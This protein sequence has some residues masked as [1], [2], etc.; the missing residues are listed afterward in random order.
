[1]PEAFES[2]ADAPHPCVSSQSRPGRTWQRI[3]QGVIPPAVRAIGLF[4]GA[5]LTASP[6]RFVSAF[7]CIEGSYLDDRERQRTVARKEEAE[8][9]ICITSERLRARKNRLLV[10]DG[11]GKLVNE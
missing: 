9:L 10:A 1:M 3:L 4:S 11:R 8:L 5:A 2:F 6:R 7:T